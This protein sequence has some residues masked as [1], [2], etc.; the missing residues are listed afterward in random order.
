MAISIVGKNVRRTN[1]HIKR[2]LQEEQDAAA[3][4]ARAAIAEARART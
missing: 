3:K 1:A 4:R 2:A